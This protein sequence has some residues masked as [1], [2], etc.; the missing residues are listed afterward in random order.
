M[1][2]DPQIWGPH[3]WFFLHTIALS[4]PTKA[5]DITKKIY[6]TFI[7][8]L[9]LFLPIDEIGNSFS[10]LLDKYP[11][12]PYLDSR[13]SFIKWMH[14]I[15]NKINISLNK[16]EISLDEAMKKYYDN[17]RPKQN[18]NKDEKKRREKLLFLGV[19]FL[20]IIISIYF[21]NK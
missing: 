21:H 14:F 11:V 12:K 6:Y 9:P 7:H 15:H 1:T 16:P 8:N 20:L 3:Y 17:Y 18:K 19:L 10:K 5:N 4:Y 2:L 13:K